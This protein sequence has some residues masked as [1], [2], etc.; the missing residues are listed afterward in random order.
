M[1]FFNWGYSNKDLVDSRIKDIA[2][3]RVNCESELSSK[4][5]KLVCPKVS[6]PKN[7]I[8]YLV[9]N[10]SSDAYIGIYDSLEKAKKDGQLST[11]HNCRVIE[12]KINKCDHLNK[13]V[14]EN[15]INS[16]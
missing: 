6:K 5:V 11:Y 8:C 16:N 7:D 3:N 4:P 2:K 10:S 15:K 9:V 12:F 1:N 13:I 14:F